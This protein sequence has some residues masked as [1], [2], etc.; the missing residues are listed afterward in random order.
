MSDEKLEPIG[1]PELNYLTLQLTKI[2]SFTTGCK[3][4]EW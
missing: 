3:Y 1:M 2:Y 4:D